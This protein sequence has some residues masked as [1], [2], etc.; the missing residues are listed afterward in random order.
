MNDQSLT[1]LSEKNVVGILVYLH[2]GPK[3][4]NDLTKVVS[5]YYS[6]SIVLEKLRN[7]GLIRSWTDDTRYHARWHELT[8]TGKS[9]VKK[10][11]DVQ[12]IL[13]EKKISNSNTNMNREISSEK[14]DII[15]SESIVPSVSNSV[16]SPTL[17]K[18]LVAIQ[19]SPGITIG[20]LTNVF[21]KG[22]LRNTIH[23]AENKK[24]IFECDIGRSDG[25]S[26]YH[27][28]AKGVNLIG[29]RAFAKNIEDVVEM[30][31]NASV[32]ENTIGRS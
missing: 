6:I 10:L 24:Y 2:G 11:L 3:K 5:N 19:N 29:S 7:A 21:D 15:N 28:T 12:D 31:C 32:K 23:D 30:D 8:D 17:I 22:D 16:Q 18:I 20:E 13:S 26:G 4:E 9:V 27:I 25:K 14:L 1:I